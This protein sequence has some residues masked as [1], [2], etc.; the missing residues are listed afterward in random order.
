MRGGQ[1]SE[2]LGEGDL[3]VVVEVVLAPEE[4]DLVLEQ[5]GADLGHRRLVEVT[6][7]ADALDHGADA[8]TD[9]ADANRVRRRGGGDTCSVCASN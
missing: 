4:H 9:L 5:G 6:A 7:E 2:E 8:A 3:G 1:R